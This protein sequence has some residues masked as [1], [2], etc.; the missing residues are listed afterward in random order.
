VPFWFAWR[1][2]LR[3][4]V[5]A[6]ERGEPLDRGPRAGNLAGVA[7]AAAIVAFNGFFVASALGGRVQPMSVLCGEADESG[8][9][10]TID[11]R[12][13]DKAALVSVDFQ[14]ACDN[15]TIVH[16]TVGRKMDPHSRATIQVPGKSL[17]PCDRVRH[18]GVWTISIE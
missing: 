8:V 17:Q 3:A 16:T 6:A 18:V 7:T 13:R 12:A 14:V 1:K 15:A 2:T 4:N 9:T 10:C 5:D 11:F